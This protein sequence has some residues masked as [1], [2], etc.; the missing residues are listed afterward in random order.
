MVAEASTNEY[1]APY[2]GRL[3][4]SPLVLLVSASAH[5]R[6]GCERGV[7]PARG[8]V[9]PDTDLQPE[10]GAQRA[11][12]GSVETDLDAPVG[13]RLQ[14]ELAASEQFGLLLR[15][16]ARDRA[17]GRI[18]GHSDRAVGGAGRGG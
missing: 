15:R 2:P 18:G 4:R 5:R 14:R 17:E 3:A 1:L 12:A 9:H 16:S 10:P 8:H 11:L 13:P 6:G 7:L